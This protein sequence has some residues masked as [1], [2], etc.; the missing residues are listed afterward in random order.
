LQKG[1]HGIRRVQGVFKVDNHPGGSL[2]KWHIHYCFLS[3]Y[4]II[5]SGFI[6]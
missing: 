6:F 5:I 2:F 3:Y 1:T 4:N